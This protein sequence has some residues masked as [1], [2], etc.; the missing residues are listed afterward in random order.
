[1]RGKCGRKDLRRQLLC[2]RGGQ[3]RVTGGEEGEVGFRGERE[4]CRF[5]GRPLTPWPRLHWDVR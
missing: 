4:K 1:M 3:C 2:L 5:G